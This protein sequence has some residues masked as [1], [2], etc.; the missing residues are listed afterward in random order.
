MTMTK[1]ELSTKLLALDTSGPALQIALLLDGEIVIHT[2]DI[3]R[4]HAEI[5]FL[6]L[7]SFLEV[8]KLSYQ[9][10]TCLAVTTGPGSFTGLRIGIAAVRGLALALNIPVIGVPNLLALS[11]SKAGQNPMGSLSILVDANRGQYYVQDFLEP[12]RPKNKPVLIESIDAEV[13]LLAMG[14]ECPDD[15]RLDIKMLAKWASG[16]NPLDFPPEPTYVRAADAKP[17]TRAKIARKIES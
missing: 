15:A 4:G 12:G 16:V 6:R 11:L 1:N 5:L 9:D 7:E 2:E 14:Q 8:H 10:L 3:A 13:K 17:Q